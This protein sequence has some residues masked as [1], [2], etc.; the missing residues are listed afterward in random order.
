MT[1]AD[2]TSRVSPTVE[3]DFSIEGER[4]VAVLSQ[5]MHEDGLLGRI[6]VDNG[7]EFIST[8]LADRA[9]RHQAALEFSRPGTPTDKAR[10]ESFSRQFRAECLDQNWFQTVGEEKG[11]DEIWSAHY[12]E[13]RPPL[14]LRQQ[15]PA[16][17]LA[18]WQA[19]EKAAD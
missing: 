15:V 18:G 1:K 4:V 2:N 7:P 8:A 9:Y 3:V 16:V 11:V 17:V 12:N 13:E 6:A 10:V 19:S 14:A 5:F